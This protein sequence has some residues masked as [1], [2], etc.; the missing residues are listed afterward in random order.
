LEHRLLL[1]ADFQ[2]LHNFAGNNGSYPAAGLTAVGLTLFGTTRTG[3]VSGGYGVVY[4]INA[5][6]S[7]FQVRHTFAGADGANPYSGTTLVGSTVYGTTLFGGG[8]N[9]RT[10]YSMDTD[11]S[12]YQVVHSFTGSDGQSPWSDLLQLG[13]TLYGTTSYGGTT[14][15][16]T[17]F[18]MNL[19]GSNYQ[20]LHSFGG[21]DGSVP[22]G[23]LI[24]L[25]SAL[26]GTT[27]Q[28]GASNDGTVYSMAPDGSNFQV[29]HAF[30]NTDG[31]YPL[32]GLTPLGSALYGTTE[33]GGVSGGYGTVFRLETAPHVDSITRLTPT[34]ATTSATNVAYQVTFSESVTGVDLS[35]FQVA[36]SGTVA[37]TA[38][39]VAV[40]GSGSVY[41]VVVSGIRGNGSLHL[42]L[43]DDDSIVDADGFALGTTGAGNGNLT[44]ESYTITLP[45]PSTDYFWTG[46]IGLDQ[47]RFEQVD[48]TTIRVRETMLNGI[49]LN[50]VYDVTGITGGVIAHGYNGADRLDAGGL[51]TT[52]ARLFGDEGDDRL[53]GGQAGDT[54]MGAFGDDVII[55]GN[56]NNT[57]YGGLDYYDGGEGVFQGGDNLIVGGT[58]NDTIDGAFGANGPEGATA[59]GR[60]VIV[61]NG[62]NDTLGATGHDGSEGSNSYHGTARGSILVGGTTNLNE[63]ALA[64]VLDEWRSSRDYATRVANIFGTGV[65][66]R[67]NG[68]NF[69]QAGVTVFN[70]A[71]VDQLRGS[72]RDE[73][74]WYL[75]SVELAQ[76]TLTNVRAG[77]EQTVV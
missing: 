34:G 7:N 72:G 32:A 24:Q 4:S 12:N 66:P 52:K 3:G 64:A 23:G 22:I 10:V 42:D 77:E 5:D 41:T 53:Y 59:A 15:K 58:G 17:V 67:N 62:G 61:G 45:S 21:A 50:F 25:G 38:A 31:R 70:D 75:Y 16:G 36:T 18:S 69:L 55:A 40:T 56:G 33:S 19:D 1:A 46:T 71:A 44:G 47:V 28:G 35:D 13:T 27:L 74:D 29:V 43:V 54:L 37:A 9:L 76:D 8:L 30:N 6:S 26:Y 49:A 63:A 73:F 14:D 20:V 57:I 48:A 68:N 51:I 39:P 2:V 11:G 65:G 60:N